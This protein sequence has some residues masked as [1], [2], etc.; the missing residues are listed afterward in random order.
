MKQHSYLVIFYFL[1]FSTINLNAQEVKPRALGPKMAPSQ[2][3]K[4]NLGFR[5]F[6]EVK[7]RGLNSSLPIVDED[8][9]VAM[10]KYLARCINMEDMARLN[11]N[12]TIDVGYN[13]VNCDPPYYRGEQ[14]F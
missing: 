3:T 9:T 12:N 11:W 10:Q 13:E 1:F 14:F 2:V 6:N 4:C 8:C 5:N 7:S